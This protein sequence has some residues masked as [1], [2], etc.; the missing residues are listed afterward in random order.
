MTAD[1]RNTRET[2]QLV[3]RARRAV[4]PDGTQPATAVVD[5]GRIIEE[6]RPKDVFEHPKEERTKSFLSKVL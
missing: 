4:L 6:G 1:T 5:D 3:L 2:H